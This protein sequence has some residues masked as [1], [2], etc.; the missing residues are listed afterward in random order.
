MSIYSVQ[1][2]KYMEINEIKDISSIHVY[3]LINPENVL[4]YSNI[5]GILVFYGSGKDLNYIQNDEEFLCF[6]E[7]VRRVYE[8]EK[9]SRHIYADEL[10]KYFLDS[11]NPSLIIKDIKSNIGNIGTQNKKIYY[12]IKEV[13][14]N[15]NILEFVLE[16]FLSFLGRNVDIVH[17]KGMGTNFA[18]EMYENN[19]LRKLEFKYKAESDLKSMYVF[20]GIIN[21]N[22]EL[23]VSI[24]YSDGLLIN[25]YD[26]SN[27]VKCV[28]RLD[29]KTCSLVTEM[30]IDGEC[31]L[32]KFESLEQYGENIPYLN[33]EENSYNKYILPWKDIVLLNEVNKNDSMVLENRKDIELTEDGVKVVN[34]E[35]QVLKFS[36]NVK[37]LIYVSSSETHFRVIRQSETLKSGYTPSLYKLSNVT[38]RTCEEASIT[39]YY[40]VGDDFV[41]KE[42]SFVPT[43]LGSG[44][45]KSELEGKNFYK[46][47]RVLDSEVC[48]EYNN[49]KEGVQGY[50]LL[51]KTELKLVLGRG[52]K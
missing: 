13:E 10:T 12:R 35:D 1:N 4:E 8:S 41:V 11:M 25:L 45:Y 48:E 34:L 36:E 38:L 21:G 20:K 32:R 40:F 7:T 52:V 31:K 22:K 43:L 17:V 50:Q 3:N 27:R 46:V 19:L 33:E 47:Y 24:D 5:I 49:V 28:H 51:Q 2:E 26:S 37:S 44:V 18:L 16:N 23:Y 39:N 29:K 9:N 42:T 14:S 30:Y 15:Y 6:F